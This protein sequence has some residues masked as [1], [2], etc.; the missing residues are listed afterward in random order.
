[1]RKIILLIALCSAFSDFSYS[2]ELDFKKLEKDLSS[3]LLPKDVLEISQK[4]IIFIEEPV[5]DNHIIKSNDPKIRAVNMIAK[6]K[7]EDCIDL[8]LKRAGSLGPFYSS[9]KIE[10]DNPC[11]GALITMG[12]LSVVKLTEAIGEEKDEFR[13]RLMSYALLKIK[14][15]KEALAHLDKCLISNINESQKGSYKKAKIEVS[16]WIEEKPKVQKLIKG[17]P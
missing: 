6:F 14:S 15:K 11:I 3:D 4:L 13:L 12:E 9:N 7:L 17:S 2:Q 10:I 16:K 1:M 8:L 5:S